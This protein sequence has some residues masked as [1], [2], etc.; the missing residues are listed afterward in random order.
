MNN[1][2]LDD[3]DSFVIIDTCSENIHR[4]PLW[5]VQKNL[6]ITFIVNIRYDYSV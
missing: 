2:I 3:N 5:K 4:K 6:C 1:R